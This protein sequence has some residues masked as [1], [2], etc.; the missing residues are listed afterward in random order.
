MLPEIKDVATNHHLILNKA[1]F[2]K[3]EV[4]CKC[5]FCGEDAKVGKEKKF[6]LSLNTQKQL[7]KCWFCG[8]KGGVFRFIALLEGKSESEVISEYRRQKGRGYKP[9]PAEKLSLS[10]LK[11]IGFSHKPNWG[12]MRKR[13]LV[14]YKNTLNWVWKEWLAFVSQERQMAYRFLFMGMITANYQRAVQG[15]KTREK[16][17]GASLLK[18]AVEIL[19][20]E[21]RPNWTRHEERMA[22]ELCQYRGPVNKGKPQNLKVKEE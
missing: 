22:M 15:V 21:D 6:Y 11:L 7:F 12:A 16:E 20:Q 4:L 3:K 2:N 1:T 18:E 9:H 5:P 14:Y 13:D 19:S 17:I 10:Q 8:E